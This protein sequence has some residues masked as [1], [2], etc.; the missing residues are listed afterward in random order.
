MRRKVRFRSNSTGNPMQQFAVVDD[1]AAYMPLQGFT[2]ADL[3]Y[4]RGNAVSN[5]VHRID[6]APMT[7]Q[8][9]ALFDQIWN[10]PS[11]LDDVT[12]AVT[13]TS[14]ACTRRTRRPG[15]TS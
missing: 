7:A 11:Q 12:E 9:V 14:P 15:S 10:N 8:Y 6:D 4:E 3:G 1:K 5:M 13:T 2:T